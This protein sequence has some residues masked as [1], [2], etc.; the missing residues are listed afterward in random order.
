MTT[1]IQKA[2]TALLGATQ[3]AGGPYNAIVAG[4]TGI[5]G[6]AITKALTSDARF[7]RVY[8]CSRRPP[9]AASSVTHIPTDFLS[10]PTALADALT[11][12]VPAGERI[13]YV[14]FAAYKQEDSEDAMWETNG[15]ML[16]S[17]LEALD[18]SGIEARGLKRVLLVTGAKYYGVQLGPI[19]NPAEEDDGRVDGEGR[20]PNF[21]YNQEDILKEK[22]AG[23]SWDW[24]VSMPNDVR[25]YS[26]LIRVHA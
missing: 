7:Q 22:S 16:R 6:L 17:F 21:Y 4:A 25:A 1:L 3:S 12:A 10:A 9:P 2:Q 15:R 24:V 5:N 13:D 26:P 19:K 14:F 8:A 18:L 11:Q 20:P 23:K